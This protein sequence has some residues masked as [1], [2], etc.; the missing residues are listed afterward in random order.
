MVWGPRNLNRPTVSGLFWGRAGKGPAGIAELVCNI[1]DMTPEALAFACARLLEA[2]ALDAY[3]TPGTMK[4]GRPGWVLT[5]LCAPEREQELVR[6]IF[7]HT[8]TNGLRARRPAKY[9]LKPGAGQVRTKWG[10]VGVKL[11]RGYGVTRAK[12]EFEDAA[13]LARAHGLPYQAVFEDALRNIK[14]D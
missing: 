1:D 11:A 14:E 3:T 6:E 9:F 8:A 7:T 5:V 2:G 4:K 12:P 10:P 13:A